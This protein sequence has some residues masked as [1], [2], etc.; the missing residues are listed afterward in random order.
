MRVLALRTLSAMDIEC[1][2]CIAGGGP[3]GMMLGLL[4]ARSGVDVV[5]LEKH[6][7]FLRDFRG[8]TVHPSTLDNLDELG[9]QDA[10]KRMP[11]RDVSHL[12]VSFVDGTYRVAD[13]SRL[14]VAH[15]YIRFMPQWEF[16]NVLA[17][18][19]E[20]LPT[21]R[22]LRRHEVTDLRREGGVVR[23]VTANSPDGAVNVTATLTVA[24][25]GRT[26]VVREQSGLSSR[27]FRAPMDVLWFRVSRA[28][29]DAEGLDMHVGA[30]AAGLAIDRGEFWQVAYIV[31]KGTGEGIRARNINDFRLRVAVLFPSLA[32]RVSEIRGWDDVRTLTVQLNRL[33]QW[34]APG[35]LC[36]GDAAHAMSPVGGVGINLAIQDAVAAGRIISRRLASGPLNSRTLASIQRR[37]WLPTVATQFGQR[38]AHRFL[39]ERVLTSTTSPRAPAPLRLLARTPF[40]QGVP[41]RLVGVGIRP[42]HV[43]PRLTTT[44]F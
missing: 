38:M 43:G 22:L 33:R 23:G 41:A 16:L 15:P 9:L 37:R 5:V 6:A 32:P 36:I 12:Q 14:R 24:A 13:F 26:S 44:P 42:E 21:F 34:H 30:G 11:H 39:I 8:D 4:L 7:D 35:L 31:A 19:A 27:D 17:E 1:D 29:G 20:A 18:A 3:A 25:D 10:L 2:V 28:T 40:L